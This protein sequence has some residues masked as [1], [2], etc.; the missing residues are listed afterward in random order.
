M[1][2]KYCLLFA[3]PLALAACQS[4]PEVGDLLYPATPETY[5]AKVYINETAMPG[6]Q[7]TT[8]VLRTPY[9]VQAQAD[10]VSFYVHL[11]KPVAQDVTV[12]VAQVDSLASGFAD[13]ATALPAKFTS[14]VTPSVTIPAGSMVS[15][16]P[17]RVALTHLDEVEA[18]GV[19]PI[20]IS[21]IQ[22]EAV[23]GA[24]HQVY[25]VAV[26]YEETQSRVK[27][28]SSKDLKALTKIDPSS[29]T[30]TVGGATIA[31]LND[32]D[33]ETYYVNETPGKYELIVDLGAEKPVSAFAFQ[34]GYEK[35]YCPASVEILTSLDGTNW[36]TITDGY[37]DVAYI[38][39]T[40]STAFPFVLY[41]PIQCR[42]AKVRLGDCSYGLDY[43]D[44]YNYPVLSEVRLYQ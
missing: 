21:T 32:G 41:E 17:V 6:N 35:G 8:K 30:V 1:K 9:G 11:T 26:N 42:Y 43:G 39:N 23:A 33:K 15:S 5:E 25:Y 19:A 4:E 36:T 7:H 28:Q 20:A 3:I 22:G 12:G 18:S 24:D 44:D 27:S 14:V 13:D 10:T 40:A 29:Y 2:T 38:P 34:W 37:N 16:A 31:E